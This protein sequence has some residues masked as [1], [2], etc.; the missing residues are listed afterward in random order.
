MQLE[1]HFSV[2]GFGE[3][4]F[5]EQS[6]REEAESLGRMGR[7]AGGDRRAFIGKV[8]LQALRELTQVPK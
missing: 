5:V 4:N 2:K 6:L 3:Y 7:A 8:L 1:L